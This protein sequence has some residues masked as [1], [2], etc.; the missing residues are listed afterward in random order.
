MKSIRIKDMP[1]E[2]LSRSYVWES[3]SSFAFFSTGIS[4]FAISLP[5]LV[6]PHLSY[7]FSASI[8]V[9]FKVDK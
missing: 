6:Q 2:W 4:L 8:Y 1:A 7:S 5:N 9:S 3:S